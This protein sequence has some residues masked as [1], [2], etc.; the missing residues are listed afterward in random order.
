MSLDPT[1]PRRARLL[2]PRLPRIPARALLAFVLTVLVLGAAWMWFRD[3][4]F[5]RVKEVTVTGASTSEQAKVR[6]ALENA[7]LDQTTLHVRADSLRAAVAR[8]DSV[9]GVRVH[10]DF[11]HRMRIEVIEHK[12]VAAL[13]IGDTTL[14]ATG[15]GLIL[16]GVS[17]DEELP[18]VKMDAP[19]AGDRVDN[20]NTKAA[21]S[22]SAAAPEELRRRIDRLWTGPKGMMLAL[23]DGPD[24]V[25][26]DASDAHRKWL[27][28]TRVLADESAAGATYLDVRIPERVA[29]GG[30]GPVPEPT[31]E[32]SSGTTPGVAPGITPGI[33]PETNPQP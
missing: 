24:V 10:A 30:L 14:A 21:L 15:S 5:A 23:I 11:P 22:I 8:F 9:A 6:A 25:F 17:A 27:A 19:P 2:V 4:S 28:A 12:P 26:G 1:L 20:D 31:P 18:I 32:A 3:S 7:A 16:R 29:A 33:T 13:E